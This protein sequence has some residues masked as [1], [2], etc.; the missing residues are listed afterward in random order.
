MP[1]EEQKASNVGA[2]VAALRASSGTPIKVSLNDTYSLAQIQPE[3]GVWYVSAK[4]EECRAISPAIPDPFSGQKR[5]MFSGSGSLR[6]QCHHCPN[7][8][9]ATVADLFPYQ[10]A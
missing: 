6:F 3:T 8:I 9:T 5:E 7:E 2:M 10:W 1:T 4:C